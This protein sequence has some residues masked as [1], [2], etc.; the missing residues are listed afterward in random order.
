MQVESGSTFA[1]AVDETSLLD[2]VSLHA[3]LFWSWYWDCSHTTGSCIIVEVDSC[4]GAFSA[5]KLVSAGSLSSARLASAVGFGGKE[6][7]ARDSFCTSVF[8]KVARAARC[9]LERRWR[10]T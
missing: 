9:A 7:E 4:G 1:S 5:Q 8:C 10:F 6:R 3:K 2:A